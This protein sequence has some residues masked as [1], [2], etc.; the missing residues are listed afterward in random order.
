M[1]SSLTVDFQ[2]EDD[3]NDRQ[4]VVST[5]HGATAAGRNAILLNTSSEK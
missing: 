2:A 1:L 4:P 5:L 3:T